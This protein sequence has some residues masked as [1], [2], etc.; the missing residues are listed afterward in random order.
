MRTSFQDWDEESG[1]KI[2]DEKVVAPRSRVCQRGLPLPFHAVTTE[3]LV[4]VQLAAVP[5]LHIQ[6]LSTTAGRPVSLTA[7]IAGEP[8]VGP[9]VV[10]GQPGT[11]APLSA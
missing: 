8:I 7:P 6:E 9:G 5:P 2:G 4:A 1:A 10:T 3:A 11:G